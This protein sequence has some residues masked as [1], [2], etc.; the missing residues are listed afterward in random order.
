[1]EVWEARTRLFFDILQ[2]ATRLRQGA[3]ARQR[4]AWRGTTV[5]GE[6]PLC[7]VL[8]AIL[9]AVLSAMA[10]RRQRR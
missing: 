7:A 6:N 4:G 1:M 8:S 9:S 10:W 3:T 5:R 2:W